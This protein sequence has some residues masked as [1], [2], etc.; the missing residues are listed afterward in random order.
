MRDRLNPNR[1]SLSRSI[2]CPV[3]A[4][5]ADDFKKELDKVKRDQDVPLAS[6]GI[7]KSLAPRLQLQRRGMGRK[8][9]TYETLAICP[10]LALARAALAAAIAVKPAGRFMIRSRTRVVQRHPKGDW[11]AAGASITGQRTGRGTA[12]PYRGG[13]TRLTRTRTTRLPRKKTTQLVP[14]LR[15]APAWLVLVLPIRPERPFMC[16]IKARNFGKA[17]RLLG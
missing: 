3:L 12:G 5:Y 1:S 7:R 14:Y 8:G 9:R 15:R 2:L 16:S 4:Q 17:W 6:D 13:S 11:R 10:T